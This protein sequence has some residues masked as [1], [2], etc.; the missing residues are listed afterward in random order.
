MDK[1]GDK[2][3]ETEGEAFRVDFKTTLVYYLFRLI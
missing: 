1:E 3:A 2:R